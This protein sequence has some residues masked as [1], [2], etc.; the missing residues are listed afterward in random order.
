MPAH[1]G[2]GDAAVPAQVAVEESHRG[3]QVTRNPALQKLRIVQV[4]SGFTL[5]AQRLIPMI[6]RAHLQELGGGASI[7]AVEIAQLPALKD[8]PPAPRVQHG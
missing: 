2:D 6:A 7:H 1:G 3:R 5:L 8:I 4:R